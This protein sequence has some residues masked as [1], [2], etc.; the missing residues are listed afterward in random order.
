VM[1]S[2]QYAMVVANFVKLTPRHRHTRSTYQT[3][4]TDSAAIPVVQSWI[5]HTTSFR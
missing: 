5:A 4:V 2:P 3:T 1:W